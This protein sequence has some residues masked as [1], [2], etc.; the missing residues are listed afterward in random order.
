MLLAAPI[1]VGDVV[2]AAVGLALT[3]AVIGRRGGE[4]FGEERTG[5]LRATV[6]QVQEIVSERLVYSHTV[7][8]PFH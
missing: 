2:D 6:L 5:E 7:P 4:A 8:P 1:G 3:S